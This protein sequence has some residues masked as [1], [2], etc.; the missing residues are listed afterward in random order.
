MKKVLWSAVATCAALMNIQ[1]PVYADRLDEMISP[2]TSPVTFEDPRARTELRPIFVYHKLDEKFVTQGGNIRVYALQARFAVNDRLAIIATKDGYVQTRPDS[3]L[4]DE[5]GFANVAA[6]FKYAF[7]KDG[8]AGQIATAGLRYEIPMGNRDVLQGE[9][10]GNLNPFVSAA[11]AIGNVNL[12]AG[13]GVRLSLDDEDSSFY[14]FDLHASTKWGWFHPTAEL[15]VIHVISAGER[16][17]IADEGHDF[18]NLG[19]TESE[20]K[21]IVTGALGGRVD[22]ADNISWGAAYQVPLTN[23][24]GSHATD[25]RVTTDLI[26]S[27]NS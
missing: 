23:G 6:G 20:G 8:A 13:T 11:M 21:T 17:P 2:I 24:A 4:N 7:Y 1:S 27:F 18:F 25:W 3:V 9:G 5:E 22:L 15:G 16:L 26:F 19:A 10:D 12:M 14:D